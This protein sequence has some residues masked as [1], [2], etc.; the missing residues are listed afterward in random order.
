MLVGNLE[1]GVVEDKSK[2]PRGE[3]SSTFTKAGNGHWR[4]PIF[5]LRNQAARRL[6]PLARRR[7]RTWR[8]LAVAIRA[9]K[10]CV[11]LRFNTLGWNVLFMV[12]ISLN[13]PH[14]N[15]WGEK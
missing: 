4:E 11:R 15:A 3:E 8:P 1:S 14:C 2:I 6:R 7:L 13:V 12:A 10:P 5:P 9:R